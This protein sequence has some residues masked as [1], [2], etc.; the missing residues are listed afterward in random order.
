MP[1][2]KDDLQQVFACGG[3]IFL[4]QLTTTA[5]TSEYLQKLP[6]ALRSENDKLLFIDMHPAGF[7]SEPGGMNLHEFTCEKLVLRHVPTAT[8]A[9]DR[10]DVSALL[11]LLKNTVDHSYLVSYAPIKPEVTGALAVNLSW[12]AEVFTSIFI[13]VDDSL[14]AKSLALALGATAIVQ[15]DAQQIAITDP[16]TNKSL[17]PIQ[18]QGLIS[19][20]T[21]KQAGLTFFTQIRL[22]KLLLINHKNGTRQLFSVFLALISLVFLILFTQGRLTDASSYSQLNEYRKLLKH[23]DLQNDRVLVADGAVTFKRMLRSAWHGF[24]YVQPRDEYLQEYFLQVHKHNNITD[25]QSYMNIDQWVPQAGTKFYFPIPAQHLHLR[26]D[27]LEQV[28]R[29][30]VRLTDDPYSFVS[31]WY[32]I[33]P[34]KGRIHRGI[35][36]AAAEGRAVFTPVSGKVRLYSDSLLGRTV[37]VEQPNLSFYFGHCDRFLVLDGADVVAGD[38]IALAG[39]TGR[40]T[41]PHIHFAIAEK[42]GRNRNFINPYDWVK[43]Q[44]MEDPYLIILRKLETS[45]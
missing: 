32:N 6:Y 10:Y 13:C 36:I 33:Q 44:L 22:L 2:S 26:V 37:V 12:C 40:A 5:D 21:M 8:K 16:H 19:Y 45:L 31:E 15:F 38:K 35:D 39:A 34:K 30:L 1:S 23:I 25:S 43:R 20:E 27:S 18:S 14:D 7:W 4:C 28:Y 11:P 42:K 24:L 29:Y 41:G 9:D 3:G 17:H